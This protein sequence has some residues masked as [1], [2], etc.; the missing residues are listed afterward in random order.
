MIIRLFDI[1]NESP[2]KLWQLI[3]DVYGMES[4][5]LHRWHW[6]IEQHPLR[7]RLRIHIAETEGK[8]VGMTV[9]IPVQL[10]A[11]DKVYG[12]EFGTNTMVHPDFRRHGIVKTLYQQAI[13][14]GN[15]QLS[16]GTA[17]A[18]V[19]QLEAMGY[20]EITAAKT[21][22]FLLAPLRWLYRKV[23]GRQFP[24][25]RSGVKSFD[26]GYTRIDRFGEIG[27]GVCGGAPLAVRRTAEWMN[28]RYCDIPH[29]TYECYVRFSGTQIVAWFVI[30][31][32]ETVAYLVDLYWLP[33]KESL[34]NVVRAAVQTARSH[35]SIQLIY[36]GTLRDVHT[37]MKRQG[38]WEKPARPGFR[39]FSKDA[40][41]DSVQWEHS[42]FVQGDG[43]YD[44]L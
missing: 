10:I 43:D 7:D 36:W 17:P 11:D 31:Y 22:V 39:F 29:R 21:Q 32:G 20:K 2:E 1:D 13:D 30:R 4:N 26:S 3:Q 33:A 37:E 40:Y 12:A 44:Y 16:K 19:R 24:F 28:W 15:L 35:G 6:E 8:V 42:H 25:S 9:R 41:W 5:A 27:E 18:M 38:A 34:P 14:G 23:T